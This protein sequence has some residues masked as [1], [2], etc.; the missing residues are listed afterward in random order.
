[1]SDNTTR[2]RDW[3]QHPPYLFPDYGGTTLRAPAKPLVPLPETLS[4]R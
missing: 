1:M 3:S 4:E 2:P